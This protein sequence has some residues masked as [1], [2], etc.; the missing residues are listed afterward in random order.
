MFSKKLYK[1]A[2]LRLGGRVN[3]GQR[4]MLAAHAGD[5][6]A[7]MDGLSLARAAG[8]ESANYTN[9]QYGRLGHLLAGALQH[10][11]AEQIWTRL[12]GE[13]TRHPQHGRIQWRMHPGLV[14]AVAELG[15]T[16]GNV[17]ATAGDDIAAASEALAG[18]DAT[19]RETLTA[20]RLGQGLFRRRLV[21]MWG[22]CSVTGCNVLE[23]LRASH[24]KPWRD[25]DNRERLD[26]HNGLLLLGTLDCLFDTGLIT[27]EADGVLRP[28]RQ[29]TK[30]QQQ[31]VSLH[32][33]MRLRRVDEAHLPYLA[34]HRGHVFLR[35]GA[36]RC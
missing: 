6:T 13:D 22:S 34:W 31:S 20:A 23:A 2:L 30:P 8:Q 24:I 17:V 14:E 33:G 5:P 29:L 28:S 26:H 27:F 10:R 7:T 4:R 19:T 11:P 1:A 3:E 32:P 9:G 15:W 16:S 21:E 35:S 25:C 12:V 36:E 18:L